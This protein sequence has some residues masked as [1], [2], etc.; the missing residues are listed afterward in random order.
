MD[1]V[2]YSAPFSE[3][4]L[5]SHDLLKKAVQLSTG[6]IPGELY[7]GPW[8]KPFFPDMPDLHFSITHSGDYWLCA[9]AS[10]PVGLDL[11]I[12][13]SF[14]SPGKLSQRFFHPAED[15][16]LREN[17]YE[18]FFSLWTAKES[19]VKY[20]GRGFHDDPASF[21][22]VSEDGMFPFINGGIF[23][24]PHFR[25]GYSLCLCAGSACEITFLPLE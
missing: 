19:W 14:L 5:H 18:K 7:F 15:R 10:K 20:T 6:D 2:I 17:D 12:H 25:D 21:S 13:K 16:F 1:T 9:F 22:V 11:Q 24:Q 4:S 8:G 23:H 3:D